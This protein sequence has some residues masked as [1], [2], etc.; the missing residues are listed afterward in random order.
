MTATRPLCTRHDLRPRGRIYEQKRQNA[1]QPTPVRGGGV[2]ARVSRGPEGGERGGGLRGRA[3][4]HCRKR[5]QTPH[6]G[7][8]FHQRREPHDVRAGKAGQGHGECEGPVRHCAR[9]RA[10]CSMAQAGLAGEG[11]PDQLRPARRVGDLCFTS[12]GKNTSGLWEEGALVPTQAVKCRGAR[13]E[14]TVTGWGCGGGRRGIRSP[15]GRER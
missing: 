15:V 5:D 3:G 12:G 14:Q 9:G 1:P 6:R 10:G 13:W 8:I 4:C 11:G 2:Q 7:G